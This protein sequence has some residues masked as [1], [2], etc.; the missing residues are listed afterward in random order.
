[1]PHSPLDPWSPSP[2]PLTRRTWLLGSAAACS[3][4][5][6]LNAQA[7]TQPVTLYTSNPKSVVDA[8]LRVVQREAPQLKVNVVQGGTGELLQRLATEAAAPKADLLWGGAL[9]LLHNASRHMLPYTAK[10]LPAIAPPL[11]DPQHRWIG[12]NVHVLGMLVNTRKLRSNT[13]PETWS[14]LLDPAWKG[15]IAMADPTRSG[16]ACMLLYG[17]HRQ[18]GD[19]ALERLAANAVVLPHSSAVHKAVVAGKFAVALTFEY[20]MQQHLDSGANHI[21]MLYPREGS[22]LVPEGMFLVKGSANLPA[23]RTLYDLL[24]GKPVQQTLLEQENR[25]PARTDIALTQYSTLPELSALRIWEL[26][27]PQAE[28]TPA[29]S[30][31]LWHKAVAAAR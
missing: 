13:A 29:H 10:E 24:L 15:R 3:G 21:R 12:S 27:A 11:V 14:D 2:T 26:P 6:A 20:A 5:V 8:A 25:R 18:F 16:T 30:L 17:L 19:S 7:A 9:G 4:W 31:A 1:M 22:Y 23:A 28:H